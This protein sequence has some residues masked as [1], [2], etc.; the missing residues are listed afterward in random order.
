MKHPKKNFKNKEFI[1]KKKQTHIH[2]KKFIEIFRFI[3]IVHSSAD[4]A[5]PLIVKSR[6]CQ[7]SQNI[8]EQF[9]F[10]SNI[11]RNRFNWLKVPEHV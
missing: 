10:E 7:Y 9:Q 11:H 3:R 5:C 6:H 2:V 4:N 8:E 1:K